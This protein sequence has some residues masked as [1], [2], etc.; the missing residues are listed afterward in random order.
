MSG[1]RMSLGR[2]GKERNVWDKLIVGQID[3]TTK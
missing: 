2:K 1:D 3:C